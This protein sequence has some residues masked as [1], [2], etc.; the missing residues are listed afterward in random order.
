VNGTLTVNGMSF[1]YNVL[2]SGNVIIA[3]TADVSASLTLN[4]CSFSVNLSTAV[5]PLS[6]INHGGGSITVSFCSFES[7][8]LNA[9]PLISYNGFFFF[10][11]YIIIFFI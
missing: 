1:V 4:N 11:L 6:I 5:V 7:I 10:S 8:S 9:Q 3:S 2:P